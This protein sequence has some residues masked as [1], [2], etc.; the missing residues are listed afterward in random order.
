MSCLR[1]YPAGPCTVCKNEICKKYLICVYCCGKFHKK[2]SL[3]CKNEIMCTRSLNEKQTMYCGNCASN[4]FP[5]S[6]VENNDLIKCYGK[7]R[8]SQ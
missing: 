6:L 1:A 4:L 3:A 7:D 8:S 2:C 5:F